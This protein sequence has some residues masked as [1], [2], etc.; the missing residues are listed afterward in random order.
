M[1]EES[2]T[3]RLAMVLSGDSDYEERKDSQHFP[4]GRGLC[5]HNDPSR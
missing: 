2:I 1:I 4:G 3:N 5:P